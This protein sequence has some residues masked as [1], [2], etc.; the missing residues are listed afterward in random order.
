MASS[1]E[2]STL[3]D[4]YTQWLREFDWQTFAT[5][6]FE[7]PR[8]VR[9][10]RDLVA[11][12]VSSE[13]PS[14]VACIVWGSEPHRTGNGHCHALIKWHPWLKAKNAA[15]A[16]AKCWRKRFGLC[17]LYPF[18]PERGAVYY[19]TKYVL[20]ESF[21][22]DHWGISVY[23]KEVMELDRMQGATLFDGASESGLRRE[24]D[25]DAWPGWRS[26]EEV[27]A[28]LDQEVEARRIIEEEVKDY[29]EAYREYREE[30]EALARREEEALGE[31]TRRACQ[32]SG[33]AQSKSRQER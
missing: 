3:R 24:P 31:A 30:V 17:W 21:G 16:F 5:L 11:E 19:V 20:K 14:G 15:F 18:D 25:S 22:E 10:A 32:G 12:F 28:T 4:S 33:E 9:R 23:G 7:L 2:H 27:E 8:S 26:Q 6:T 29:E 1:D 13:E